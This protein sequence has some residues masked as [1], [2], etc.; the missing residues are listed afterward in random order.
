M[1]GYL[2]IV[3][4]MSSFMYQPR[5]DWT[6]CWITMALWWITQVIFHGKNSWVEQK[7]YD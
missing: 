1:G 2:R 5:C 4:A 3:Q 6:V 7:I